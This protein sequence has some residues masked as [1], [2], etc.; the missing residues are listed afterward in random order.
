[1]S[2]NELGDCFRALAEASPQ[3]AGPSV[4]QRLLIEFRERRDKKAR[5]VYL[6]GVAA[7]VALAVLLYLMPWRIQSAAQT[8]SAMDDQKLG[9]IEL[10]YAQSGVPMEQPVIVRVDIPVS[11]LDLMGVPFTPAARSRVRADLLVGQDGV[12][13]GVRFVE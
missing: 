5:W 9:F 13:R 12:A 8:A 11:E 2:E 10:P 4:Q 1:M 3:Q 6:A 7:S